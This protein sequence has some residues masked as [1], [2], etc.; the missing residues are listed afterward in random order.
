[1]LRSHK[2]LAM[3]TLGQRMGSALGSALGSWKIYTWFYWRMCQSAYILTQ[4]ATVGGLNLLWSITMKTARQSEYIKGNLNYRYIACCC[5]SGA[6]YAMS[7][8]GKPS[9]EC[10]LLTYAYDGFLVIYFIEH[11]HECWLVLTIFF[12][13]SDGMPV[14]DLRRSKAVKDYRWRKRYP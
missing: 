6:Q 4:P 10:T 5:L 14:L 9:I 2:Q 3:T 13:G 1:M 11:K 8:L 7:H 12:W